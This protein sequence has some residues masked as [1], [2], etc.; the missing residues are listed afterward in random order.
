MVVEETLAPVRCQG[1]RVLAYLNDWLVIAES[2]EQVELR[3]FPIFSLW[4]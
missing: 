1:I 4:A 3:W 2:I